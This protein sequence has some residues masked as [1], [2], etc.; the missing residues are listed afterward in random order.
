MNGGEE[1]SRK[2]REKD[3]PLSSSSIL[4]ATLVDRASSS[5]SLTKEKR[6][7]GKYSPPFSLSLFS[8][9]YQSYSSAFSF[10]SV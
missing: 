2:R 5:V 3:L 8:T 9:H 7:N 6:L 1:S 10:R 4:L